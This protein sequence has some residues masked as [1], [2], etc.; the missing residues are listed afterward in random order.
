MPGHR[1]NVL[2][3]LLPCWAHTKLN[4]KTIV[5]DLYKQVSILIINNLTY[6]QLHM[7]NYHDHDT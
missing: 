4:L 2:L 5:R 1:P 3:E 7:R 6:I